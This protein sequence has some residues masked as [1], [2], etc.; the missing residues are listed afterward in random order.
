MWLFFFLFSFWPS[1]AESPFVAWPVSAPEENLSKAK[2]LNFKPFPVIHRPEVTRWVHFF[3][4]SSSPY[5]KLWLKR[6][7][8][9]FPNME[10]IFQDSGLP[11][12]LVS[13]SLV[14]SSLSAKAV[15]SAKAVGYW[16]FIEPT[17]LKFGLRINSWIDERRDFQKSTQ[18]AVKY[19]H[20]LYEEFE[21]WLL[22]MSAYNMGESRLRALIQKHK[23][24]NFWLLSQKADFPTETALYVPKVLAAVHIVRDPVSY[25]LSEF[26][27][28]PPYNYDIF[29]IPGGTNL[30]KLSQGAKI[31]L[32]EIKL[33]NPDLKSEI[34][35]K[36]ISFHQVRIPKGTGILISNWLDK[37][38]SID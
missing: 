22:V 31:S 35:P 3:S 21:D 19:L 18:A 7:Y 28:L 32:A 11:K 4:H 5:F 2:K 30:K 6:A 25:G 1:L 38:P 20:Q 12:E 8:R 26:V 36:S 17:G 24:K 16:Q 34:I 27:V 9:Y 37:Q 14:E 10:R 23:T 13:M 33:L 29:F 15:S